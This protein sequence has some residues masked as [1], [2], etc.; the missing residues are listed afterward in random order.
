MTHIKSGEQAMQ[1][2]RDNMHMVDIKL[3]SRRVNISTST[4]YNIRN[5]RTKWP[6]EYTLFALCVD[7]DLEWHLRK[8]GQA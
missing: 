7:L 8:R 6:R 2:V 5:G 4:L 1:I 3:L